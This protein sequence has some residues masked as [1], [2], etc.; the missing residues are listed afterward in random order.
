MSRAICQD[1]AGSILSIGKLSEHARAL[2]TRPERRDE[3]RRG[4]IMARP[5]LLAGLLYCI[6][7]GSTGACLGSSMRGASSSAVA[8]RHSMPFRESLHDFFSF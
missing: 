2:Y 4:D 5:M 1:T 6:D 7:H 3:G 8:H